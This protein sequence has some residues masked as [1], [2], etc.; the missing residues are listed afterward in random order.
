MRLTLGQLKRIIREAIE[1]EFAPRRGGSSL[2][3]PPPEPEPNL[4]IFGPPP[5]SD[6]EPEPP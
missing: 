6:N 3:K 1:D 4:Y 5:K 2:P